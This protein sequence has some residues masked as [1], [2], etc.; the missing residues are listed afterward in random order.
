[1]RQVLYKADK[2]DLDSY[3]KRGGSLNMSGNLQLNNILELKDYQ[4][5]HLNQ[6]MKLP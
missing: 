5:Q 4:Q 3:I 1:M 2:R 6:V